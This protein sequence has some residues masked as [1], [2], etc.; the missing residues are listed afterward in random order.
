ML[1]KFF[2]SLIG[3]FSLLAGIRVD[4]SVEFLQP[5][6]MKASRAFVSELE[7]KCQ[8][9]YCDEEAAAQKLDIGSIY[10]L[11][12]FVRYVLPGDRDKSMVFEELQDFL[13]AMPAEKRVLYKDVERYS[14]Y[15]QLVP[16][17][18]M[19]EC[20]CSLS[21]ATSPLRVQSE[22]TL[23]D[24]VRSSVPHDRA[25]RI[26]E[27]G[28]GGLLSLFVLLHKLTLEGYKKFDINAIDLRY[29]KTIER[30]KKHLKPNQDRFVLRPHDYYLL[31]T[32]KDEINWLMTKVF[33]KEEFVK[34]KFFAS[35][36]E[37]LLHE[38]LDN[39]RLHDG[40][41]AFL[42]WFKNNGILI[43]L[44][45]YASTQDYLR[46]YDEV[47]NDIVFAI[48]VPFGCCIE[49]S[50]NTEI[51]TNF[52][53]VR[54]HTLS[55]GGK[56]LLLSSA[57][58]LMKADQTGEWGIN[59]SELRY[60]ANDLKEVGDLESQAREEFIEQLVDTETRLLKNVRSIPPTR[61][62]SLVMES[63]PFFGV[64]TV[65]IGFGDKKHIDWQ[66]LTEQ[67]KPYGRPGVPNIVLS[68]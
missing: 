27:I 59:T 66:F 50:P 46:E 11:Y 54:T 29:E 45:L 57:A 21:R 55:D 9:E 26:T 17:Y 36:E 52:N 19:D 13:Y 62:F 8:D 53:D 20:C 60:R 25:I 5:D 43:G 2:I 16:L 67:G 38:Y 63:G 51:F 58:V 42:N 1:K 10:N 24:A 65:V 68:Q 37:I 39:C 44:T 32:E 31:P 6:V 35:D 3:V 4:T 47:K 23:I 61:Q 41:V 34:G 22:R 28:S 18:F 33:E 30:Y 48:D 14:Q 56:A 7:N 12:N 49:D 64:D 15:R 40:I